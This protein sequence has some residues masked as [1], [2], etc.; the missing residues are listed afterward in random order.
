MAF[1]MN[2][3]VQEACEDLNLTG[4]GEAVEGRVA[5]AAEG[6][7]NR[8]IAQ[9]NGD[10][11][12]AMTQ[13]A[14]DVNASGSIYFR[15]LEAGESKPNTVDMVPPDNVD[16]VARKIGMRYMR[17]RPTSR[18][19]LDRTQTYSFPTHWTYG[20]EHEIAPSGE[21]RE[22]GIIRVN[23]TYPTDYRVYVMSQ[24]PKY[25][26]GDTIYLSSLYRN[27]LLYATE[28]KLVE[29]MKLKSYEDQVQRNLDGATKLIDTK[30]ANN[31]PDT[32]E[33]VPD[34]NYLDG[35]YNVMGGTGF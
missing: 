29:L 30:H 17:L 7:V 1:A 11:Y 28:M 16:G 24:L 14:L 22:V 27:L 5:A 19:V 25:K 3:L 23:G 9:L 15:K 33:N 2:D 13:H 18:D 34:G 8:A 20:T 35:Y 12:V 31:A 32:P 26:L 10:G 6:C 4:T 21:T